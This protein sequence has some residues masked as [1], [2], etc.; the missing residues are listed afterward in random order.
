[1][2]NKGFTLIE[3][4]FVI[5]IIGLMGVII[6][7]NLN[8]SLEKANKSQCEDFVKYI[9][10]SACIY[11]EMYDVN[12]KFDSVCKNDNNCT[13]SCEDDKCTIILKIDVLLKEGMIKEEIDP[14]TNDSKYLEDSVTIT[15]APVEGMNTCVYS[16]GRKRYE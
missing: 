14:C 2:K 3:I 1:M 12:N 11:Y 8:K 15:T 5:A 9:E 13:K 6:S 16:K 10:T 4:L 7:V